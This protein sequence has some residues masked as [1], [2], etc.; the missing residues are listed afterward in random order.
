MSAL[1]GKSEVA[2]GQLDFSFFTQ[3]GRQANGRSVLVCLS[4][5][6]FL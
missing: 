1:K 6:H 3:N 5:H 4:L 2:I